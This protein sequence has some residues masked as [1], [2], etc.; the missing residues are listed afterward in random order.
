MEGM[1]IMEKDETEGD[2]FA[3]YFWAIA[4][5]FFTLAIL[6]FVVLLVIAYVLEISPT[7]MEALEFMPNQGSVKFL[8]DLI[9]PMIT[10]GS[11]IISGFSGETMNFVAESGDLVFL[12]KTAQAMNDPQLRISPHEISL[13][14]VESFRVVD[15]E[16]GRIYFDAFAPEFDI[17]DPI[18]S[19]AASEVETNRLVSPLNRD[20]LIKSDAKLSLTGA[21]GIQAEAKHIKLEAGQD[22]TITSSEGDIILD[23]DVQLDPLALPVGGG[24]YLSE[25]AQY[26]LCICG[27]SG[28]IY[29]VS[30]GSK[31]KDFK[32]AS[33]MACVH[34]VD[35]KS[36]KHPCH[37]DE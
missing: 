32:S 3:Y 23:G 18:D 35:N 2:A 13:S 31:M 11:G 7:G 17:S 25:I 10:V 1:P 34:A 24:G 6:N 9:A 37:T 19:L 8:K 15:P 29:A 16:T 28:K 22:I 27:T 33:G 36:N 21:E 20:L 30:V 4:L 5:F 14:N 12:V 26:K